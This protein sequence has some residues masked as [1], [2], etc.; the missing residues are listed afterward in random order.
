MSSH[1]MSF[2]TESIHNYATESALPRRFCLRDPVICTKLL[3]QKKK[4][5]CG[6]LSCSKVQQGHF[7]AT[8][9]RFMTAKG[10]FLAHFRDL[11][12]LLNT[13]SAYDV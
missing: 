8:K 12:D 1:G 10:P 4:R 3:L 9:I 6:A 13:A 5:I 11:L 7:Q 2:D